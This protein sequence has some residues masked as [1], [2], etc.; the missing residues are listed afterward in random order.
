MWSTFWGFT[1]MEKFNGRPFDPNQA[2]PTRGKMHGSPSIFVP[3]QIERPGSKLKID[4][5]GDMNSTSKLAR[6]SRVVPTTSSQP[7]KK[8]Q[9]SSHFVFLCCGIFCYTFCVESDG[10]LNKILWCT[11]AR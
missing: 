10:T 2:N 6:A 9:Q 7:I 11:G 8:Q 1:I 3:K 5:T 4:V